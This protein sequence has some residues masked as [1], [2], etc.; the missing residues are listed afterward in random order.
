MTKLEKEKDEEIAKLKLDI[1][2]LKNNSYKL[3]NVK[4]YSQD[5]LRNELITNKLDVNSKM[6]LYQQT[7]RGDLNEFKKLIDKGFPILEEVSAAKYY[8]TPSTMPCIMVKWKSLFI[9][10]ICL[11]NKENI[12]WLWNYKVMI[13]EHLCYAY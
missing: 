2:R 10:W 13:I 1:E 6:I 11:H 12:I 3:E 9:F 5:E 8:W 7:V 4:K